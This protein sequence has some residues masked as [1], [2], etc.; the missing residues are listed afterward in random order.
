MEFSLELIVSIIGAIGATIGTISAIKHG[1][2]VD[3][4][5]TA[6]SWAVAAS[7][8]LKAKKK[9]EADGATLETRE[10]LLTV[11]ME[12][13]RKYRRGD[14]TKTLSKK[15]ERKT[16]MEMEAVLDNI[17]HGIDAMKLIA[18]SGKETVLR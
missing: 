2:K 6:D 3:L 4:Q 10:S 5:K 15:L 13:S 11:A 14:K 17:D 9:G 18:R 8:M 7:A 16:K 12:T 1:S